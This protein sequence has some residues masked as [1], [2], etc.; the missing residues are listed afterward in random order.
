MDAQ[1]Q[2]ENKLITTI[3][4]IL[5]VPFL[6]IAW[7]KNSMGTTVYQA[8]QVCA[9]A[10]FLIFI[11]ST[12]QKIKV[13]N[14]I[15]LFVIYQSIL[16]FSTVLNSKFGFGI[17]TVTIAAVLLFV[18]IQSSFYYIILNA[19]CIIVVFSMIINLPMMLINRNVPNAI[20]FIG[21]K[22]SLSMFLIPGTFLLLI[23]SL[24]KHNKVSK[25]C[26]LAVALCLISVF[27][28][29]SGTGI[30]VAVLSLVLIFVSKNHKPKKK[31]Y[32]GFIVFVYILFLLFSEKLF[33]TDGWISFTKVLG[34]NSDLT[35]RTTIW[36][37]A[38]GII[39]EHWFIGAGR[40]TEI[41]YINTWGERQVIYESHNFILEILMEGG[42]VAL[43]IFCAF[44]Y[45][46][47]KHLDL[48]DVKCRIIFVAIC[49]L[50]VNGLTESI[51]NNF[52]AIVIL[53]I[54]CRYSSEDRSKYSLNEQQIKKA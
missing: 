52:F 3:F 12:V 50:L 47:I 1:R 24:E 45:K 20:F 27:I 14:A 4:V 42:I 15:A 2:N 13:N 17:F 53:G 49:I 33:I 36:A 35:A 11:V 7:I 10:L 26:I 19:L 46:C 22:N 31:F 25:G 9:V 39:N 34:K 38:K 8:W 29:F 28:G 16:L 48:N 40:G 44:F 37:I 21:G 5:L 41:S 43:S 6:S 54:A 51:V 18:L 23:N 30:V 32:I